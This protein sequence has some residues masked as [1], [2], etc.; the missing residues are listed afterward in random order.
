MWQNA[1][2]T[3]SILKCVSGFLFAV[4]KR[5][6]LESVSYC[7]RL[8]R[9]YRNRAWFGEAAMSK[10][11]LRR[12]CRQ[13]MDPI[14]IPYVLAPIAYLIQPLLLAKSLSVLVVGPRTCLEPLSSLS[15]TP[16]CPRWS[17]PRSFHPIVPLLTAFEKLAL[18]LSHRGF[19]SFIQAWAVPPRM[20]TL[21]TVV[22]VSVD[23]PSSVSF[24]FVSNGVHA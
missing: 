4:T 3:C 19:A 9:S 16:T 23:G 6:H 11:S 1:F 22:A 8:T 15:R 24:T 14:E 21:A 13:G 2:K 10:F 12:Y 7:H 5:E 20:P 18:T 17:I